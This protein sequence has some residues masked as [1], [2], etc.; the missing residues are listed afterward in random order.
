MSFNG[1]IMP[2]W[3][4]IAKNLIGQISF[5]LLSPVWMIGLCLLYVDERVRAEGYDI[6]LM[7][8]ARLGE[9]PSVPETYVNPLHPAL[10]NSIAASP[11]RVAA[12]R[13]SSITTLGLK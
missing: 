2:A 11:Q 7:A 9:I 10:A 5:I 12:G 13:P 1:D 3:Y 4:E 6:E 8:A